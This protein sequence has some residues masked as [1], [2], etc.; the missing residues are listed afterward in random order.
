MKDNYY[1]LINSLEWWGAERVAVNFANTMIH[2]WKEVYIIT[3]KSTNFYDLPQW[4][5]H[6]S[7]SNVKNNLLMFLFI[8]WYVWQFKKVL[9]KYHLSDGMSLLEIANFVHILAKDR[10]VISFRTH[11]NFFT[12]IVWYVQKLLIKRLYPRASKIVVNSLENKYDIAHYLHVSEDKIEVQMN[13]LDR[14][15]I[16]LL[17]NDSVEASLLH[18]VRNKKVLIT[19]GRLIASKQH[20]K[21]LLALR[22]VYDVFD[23]DWV[24]LIVGDWPEKKRLL[25]LVE[26]LWLQNH[27]LFLWAQKNVFKYLSLAQLFLYASTVE[28]FPNVLLEARELWLPI[29]TSDFKSGAKEVILWSYTKDIWKKIRYPYEGKYGF[30]ID[31]Q[32]YQQQFLDVY[33]DILFSLKK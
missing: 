28:W 15:K 33:R 16:A 2:E 10:A 7:L 23:K 6:L 20:N 17:K 30:L 31:P 13:V 4:V 32:N 25:V 21:I 3:L 26:E 9:K 19:T 24:Y 14:E 27:V 1:F 22:H 5:H 29:I 18:K 8:P 11:I 12:G